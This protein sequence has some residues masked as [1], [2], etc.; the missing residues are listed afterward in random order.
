MQTLT[1][2]FRYNRWANARVFKVCLRAERALLEEEAAGTVGTIDNS[3]RHMVSVEEGFAALLA[4]EEAASKFLVTPTGLAD[5][6]FKHELA[7]YA[8][9]AAE[10]DDHFLEVVGAATP[11]FS[12]REVM[13]PWLQ[14]AM[15]AQQAMMQVLVHNGHHRSQV[16][17]ALGDRGV[18]VPDLDYVIMLAKERQ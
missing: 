7:W 18:K 16:F 4:G 12:D 9:R 1:E 2:F 17:S 3:L 10:L 5:G 8:E 14:F 6:Y 13:V 15:T 11:E